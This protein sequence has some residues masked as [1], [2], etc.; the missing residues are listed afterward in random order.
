M[1][2]AADKPSSAQTEFASIETAHKIESGLTLAGLPI[3][4]PPATT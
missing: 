2:A 1:Y 3:L 4:R